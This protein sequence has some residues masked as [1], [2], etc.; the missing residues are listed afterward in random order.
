MKKQSSLEEKEKAL[1]ARQSLNSIYLLGSLALATVIGWA[2]GSWGVF[3]I[4][5]AVLV[6]ANLHARRIRLEGGRGRRRR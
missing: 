3:L 2:T 5:L 4:S 1:G 6:I